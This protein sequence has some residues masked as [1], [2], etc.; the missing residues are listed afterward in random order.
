MPAQDSRVVDHLECVNSLPCTN[1][2]QKQELPGSH[3]NNLQ[4][5][6]TYNSSCSDGW[7][8]WDVDVLWEDRVDLVVSEVLVIE[9]VEWVG[10]PVAGAVW[11]S[12]GSLDLNSADSGDGCED[13]NNELHYEIFNA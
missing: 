13:G 6:L 7:C 11:Q 5:E 4:V 12:W 9:S 1:S 8:N 10:L 3:Y 2:I